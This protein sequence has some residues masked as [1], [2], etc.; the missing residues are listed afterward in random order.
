ML[1]V[2]QLLLCNVTKSS[3]R[4]CCHF[5]VHHIVESVEWEQ[6][7]HETPKHNLDKQEEDGERQK[8]RGNP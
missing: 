6:G 5:L 7:H 8:K 4:N 1:V 3:F 2:T